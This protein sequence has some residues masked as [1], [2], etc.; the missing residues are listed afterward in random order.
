[1]Y[2]VSVA[3]AWL[4]DSGKATQRRGGGE[5]RREMGGWCVQSTHSTGAYGLAENRR[6]STALERGKSTTKGTE[7]TEG[8]K[9]GKE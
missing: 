6:D 4:A 2:A 9:W 5:T 1:M 3:L 8:K 7:N